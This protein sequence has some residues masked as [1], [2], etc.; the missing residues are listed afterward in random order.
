MLFRRL[1]AGAIFTSVIVLTVPAFQSATVSASGGFQP[2][3]P[4]ELKM[5][6]EPQAPGAPAIILFHQVERDDNGLTSHENQYFRIKILTEEGRKYA[7]V[8]IPFFKDEGNVTAVKAR[9]V[10]PDGSIADFDGK[11]FQKWMVKA[12]GLKYL[13]K[14][15][16]LPDVQVGSIIE[17]GYTLDLSEH[18]IFDS[19]WVLSN[20]LFTKAARFSLKPYT[21]DFQNFSLRWT[22]NWLPP[23]TVQPK[24]GPDHIIRMDAVNIP[25]FQSEDFMPPET[26]LKS[27]VD[28]IYSEDRF[29]P[30]VDKFWKSTGKRLNEK[31]EAFVGKRK[32]MEEAVAEIVSAN[33]SPDL[34]LQKIYDRVQKI[35]NTSYEVR[36]TE[37]EEKRAKV[38]DIAN[39]E[40]IWKRGY[41]DGRDI[42]WL[43][44]ALVRAAGFEAYGVWASGRGN[45]FFNPNMVDSSRLD[46]NVVLIKLN[47]KDI[48]GDPGSAFTPFGFLPWGETGV[49]GLRLDK[50]G[51]SWV[52]TTLPDSSASRIERKA[53]LKLSAEDG[54]LQGKLT[55]TYAGLE[56]L[57]RR[58]EERNQDAT[59]RK[60]FLEDEVKEFVPAA[61][62]VELTN[63]P[64]WKSSSLSL[65]AE[66]DLKVP[67]WAAGAGRRAMLPVGLFT[68]TEKHVFDHA[69]RVHP[70]YVQF[71][72]QK[73]DDVTIELPAGWQVSSLPATQDIPGHVVTY[74]LKVENDKGKLHLARTLNIDFLL[75]DTKY[76][77]ALRKFF[78]V[79]RTGDEEQIVLQPGT[80]AA[81]N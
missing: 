11:V 43:Y 14:T 78:Q 2:V 42:T 3:S 21:S 18:L 54:G 19:H 15:F 23:G 13:A 71:P 37:Q 26:E 76:Y 40:D 5:T 64:D 52:Q 46:S 7:D 39:V 48:Y 49:Q 74:S 44:L 38:K 45:Y 81:S 28:F 27:R 58:V 72:W 80:T 31:V 29:D 47:G 62:E 24:E 30:N 32:A 66:F 25:A 12:K 59:E 77:A 75:L 63:Q 20:E 60:T 79:V 55:V 57:S 65:V 17:Y 10:R 53:I 35:R 73:V 69:D 33:D 56:A 16:T 50:D 6:S 22:W 9:T 8:E 67:G 1:F 41:G 51:G 61:V 68:A 34:K 36:K 4:D 70:I